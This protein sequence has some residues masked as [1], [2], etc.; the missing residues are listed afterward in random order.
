[1]KKLP[2]YFVVFS[3]HFK[4]TQYLRKTLQATKDDHGLERFEIMCEEV[5]L[6]NASFATFSYE[7]NQKNFEISIPN[8]YVSE[9]IRIQDAQDI[10]FGKDKHL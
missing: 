2:K 6:S 7:S 3:E 8:Q 9:I 10:G 1:M 5:D 4:P